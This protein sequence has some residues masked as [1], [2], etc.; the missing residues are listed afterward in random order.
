VIVFGVDRILLDVDLFDRI[1]D[2]LITVLDA[3]ARGA[4]IDLKVR[5]RRRDAADALAYRTQL[6]KGFQSELPV[7]GTRRD[8]A[9]REGRG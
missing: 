3:D 4:A 7:W 5:G 8:R 1:A 2:G 6:L 9:G